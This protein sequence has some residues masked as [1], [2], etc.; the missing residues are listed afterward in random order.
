MLIIFIVGIFIVGSNGDRAIINGKLLY[1]KKS[2]GGA[3][4]DLF[5]EDY[6]TIIK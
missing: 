1:N 4:V 3:F 5:D 6:R 2:I